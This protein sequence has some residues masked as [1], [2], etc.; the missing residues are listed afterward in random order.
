MT[1]FEKEMLI[2]VILGLAAGILV[3]SIAFITG[4]Y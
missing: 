3:A 1:P 4:V 2:T